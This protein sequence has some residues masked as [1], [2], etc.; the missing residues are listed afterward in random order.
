MYVVATEIKEYVDCKEGIVDIEEIAK[1]L[2]H[3]N[4][5]LLENMVVPTRMDV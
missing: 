4:R 3:L 2:R 1:K 5:K